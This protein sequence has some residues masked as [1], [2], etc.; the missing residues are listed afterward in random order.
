MYTKVHKP[1]TSGKSVYDNKGSAGRVINYLRSEELKEQPNAFISYQ[2]DKGRMNYGSAVQNID[3][4][5][6]H[7]ESGKVKFTALSFNLSAEEAQALH[8]G[9]E[10]DT[11]NKQERVENFTKKLMGEYAQSFP[12]KNLKEEDL[13]YVAKIHEHRKKNGVLNK[14]DQTH[15]HIVVS[16]LTKDKKQF[17]N[18]ETKH[19]THFNKVN[20]FNRS[21][22]LTCRELGTEIPIKKSLNTHFRKEQSPDLKA[23]QNIIR[24]E[25]YTPNGEMRASDQVLNKLSTNTK[26]LT[27][28]ANKITVVELSPKKGNYFDNAENARKSASQIME[29]YVKSLKSESNK[30]EDL[31]YLYR[32]NNRNK[33][34]K[35]PSLEI[36]VSNRNKDMSKSVGANAKS[37]DFKK[38]SNL[39]HQFQN[40]IEREKNHISPTEKNVYRLNKHHNAGIDYKE[41]FHNRW[42]GKETK[43][44]QQTKEMLSEHFKGPKNSYIKSERVPIEIK[45]GIN[46]TLSKGGSLIRKMFADRSQEE[47]YEIIQA[48]EKRKNQELGLRR[49]RKR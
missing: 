34:D 9:K 26:G 31:V 33:K 20:F 32:V 25:Y 7:I 40:K 37:F 22:D 35:S 47:D 24:K 16:N 45:Q 18:P 44:Y 41:A 11:R 2:T 38:F 1:S 23:L 49:E 27:Q 46:Q 15:I 29:N 21:Q 8:Q 14:E 30:K 3:N 17:I 12:K 19:R 42:L 28:E 39:N 43:E 6:K 4:H 10:R 36:V 5:S 48:I 13:V